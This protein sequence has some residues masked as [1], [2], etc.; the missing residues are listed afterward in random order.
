MQYVLLVL[1]GYVFMHYSCIKKH[2]WFGGKLLYI[3]IAVCAFYF[4]LFHVSY[5]TGMDTVF[6]IFLLYSY[7]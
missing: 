2:V 3:L 1:S 5:S 4:I 6:E 7:I